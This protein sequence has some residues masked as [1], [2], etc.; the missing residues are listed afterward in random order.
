MTKMA[1]TIILFRIPRYKTAS[2]RPAAKNESTLRRPPCRRLCIMHWQAHNREIPRGERPI[3]WYCLEIGRSQHVGRTF[4]FMSVAS[5]AVCSHDRPHLQAG[6][7]NAI[8]VDM[9]VHQAGSMSMRSAQQYCIACVILTTVGR[10]ISPRH[11]DGTGSWPNPVEI[12]PHALRQGMRV[13]EASA[14]A[15]HGPIVEMLA[16]QLFHEHFIVSL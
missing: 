14:M 2:A 4:D 1:M 7:R 6:P 8:H 12:V 9:V 16:G 13:P 11:L 10:Y 15:G 5:G 3:A